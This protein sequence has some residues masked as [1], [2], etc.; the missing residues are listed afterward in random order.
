[1]EMINSNPEQGRVAYS[2]TGET[3]VVGLSGPWHLSGN[4]PSAG[5]LSQELDRHPAKRIAFETSSLSHW[6]SGLITFLVQTSEI[7]RTRGLVDDREGLPRGLRR[8]L[9]LAEAVPEKK[10]TRAEVKK[11]SFFTRVGNTSIGYGSSV[12]EFLEFLGELT[13]AFG[14]FIRGKARYRTVDLLEAIQQCGVECGRAS[15]V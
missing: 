13:R 1:M 12:G 10:G 11:V 9:E 2:H 3:L 15:S 7:C 8:M 4:V 14:K 6:D 5:S